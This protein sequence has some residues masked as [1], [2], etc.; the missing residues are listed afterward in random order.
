[1]YL[2]IKGRINSPNYYLATFLGAFKDSNLYALP[3]FS[4]KSMIHLSSAAYIL[5]SLFITLHKFVLNSI[6][7]YLKNKREVFNL[8]NN[9]TT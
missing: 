8:P 6:G 5:P 7:F 1:M 2:R 3:S 4:G 9:Y